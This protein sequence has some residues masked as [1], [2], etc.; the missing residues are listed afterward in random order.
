M[1]YFIMLFSICSIA[2]VSSTSSAQVKEYDDC[3]EVCTGK[4][5]DQYRSCKEV[6]ECKKFFEHE[7]QVC[8]DSCRS[9][10]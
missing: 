6:Q 2:I 8:I 7:A 9:K 10:H 5:I 4:Y 1:K 3:S